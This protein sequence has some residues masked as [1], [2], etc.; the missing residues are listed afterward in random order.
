MNKRR[1]LAIDIETYSAIDLTK[2]GVYRYAEDESFELL[3]FAYAYDDELV[4]IVDVAQGEDLPAGLLHDLSD[5]SVLKTAFNANF[6]ITCLS[7]WFSLSLDPAQWECTMVRAAYA[8][9]PL[10]LKACAE[11]LRLDEQ[12]K[13]VGAALIRYFSMP[14]RPTK[15][16]HGRTR[17]LP[18]HD[19]QKWELF[20]EYCVQ[21]VRTERAIWNKLDFLHLPKREHDL[22]VIDQRINSRGVLVDSK[23]VEQAIHIDETNRDELLSEA[24]S[25]TGL[26]NPNSV[27]QLKS[28]LAEAMGIDEIES[29]SKQSIKDMLADGVEPD[30]EKVLKLRQELSKTSVKKYHAIENVVCSDGRV[31]GLFQFYGANRTGRFAGRLIQLQNLPQNHLPDLDL[32]RELVKDGD[33]ETIELL[34]GNVPQVL[35]ELIRT[36]FIAREGHTLLVADYSAIE[37]RVIAWLADE[38][39]VLDV[40]RT[41]GRIYEATASMMFKVPLEEITKSSPLR[42]RGKVAQLA[43]GYGGGVNALTA[44]DVKREIPDKDKQGLINAWRNANPRIVGLWKRAELAAI[45]AVR[46]RTRV[47]LAHGVEFIGL[48]GVLLCQLPSGR[49]LTYVRP[50]TTK[51]RWGGNALRFEGMNQTTKRWG[52]IDTWGGV[53]VENI[54]QAIARDCLAEAMFKLEKAGYNIIMTIHDEVV[55]ENES[56]DNLKDVCDI[57]SEPI[58]WA[59]GLPLRADGFYTNYYMND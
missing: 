30:V 41:H 15:R 16:N 43:C 57:M 49:C 27:S 7:S 56:A 11:V 34:Y 6:E 26:D 54:V 52:L 4:S 37:A 5:P 40:F 53:L 8:G 48:N 33:K 36:A 19:L 42:A 24:S 38:E 32:A 47:K 58:S 1:K 12:K 13:S 45:K 14:C 22:W 18:V 10:S 50:H 17:N 23:L 2:S 21:D 35:S 29:L 3:L 25:L 44:M 31:R 59:E 46:E 20:K 39:W 28:W 51:N 55:I 9:L